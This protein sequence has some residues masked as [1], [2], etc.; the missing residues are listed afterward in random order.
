MPVA[1]TL[2]QRYERAGIHR[3]IHPRLHRLH[4]SHRRHRRP[5]RS[6]FA[7][8]R[9]AGFPM[10]SL[11]HRRPPR[12]SP[13]PRH[14]RLAGRRTPAWR[15]PVYSPAHRTCSPG[16][17]WPAMVVPSWTANWRSYGDD[18]LPTAAEDHRAV[19]ALAAGSARVRLR[20][21]A[22]SDQRAPARATA[23]RD[24]AARA[25]PRR[26]R[27]ADGCGGRAGAGRSC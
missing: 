12:P 7:S 19:A 22:W 24:S 21:A 26:N 20:P 11:R 6:T 14:Q 17:S 27:C 18:K 3:A 15:R 25:G 1:K 16:R 5:H 9:Y 4:Q 2:R 23:Q 8:R 13:R 10:S